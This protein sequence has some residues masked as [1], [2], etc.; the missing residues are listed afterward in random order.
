MS[1]FDKLKNLGRGGKPLKSPKPGGI[2]GLAKRD[3]APANAPKPAAPAPDAA[4][5][6]KM[7]LNSAPAKKS[8]GLSLSLNKGPKA[9]SQATP[10][11]A[12]PKS[13][14]A[15]PPALTQTAPATPPKSTGGMSIASFLGKEERPP[16]D[17]G[18]TELT[19]M[20]AE[21]VAEGT[22]FDIRMLMDDWPNPDDDDEYDPG[23]REEL[24]CDYIARAV[25]RLNQLFAEQMDLLKVADAGHPV[26]AEI[27]RIV[28][29]TYFRVKDAPGAYNILSTSDRS[30]Y[31]RALIGLGDKRKAAASKAGKT[32]K[33]KAEAS[34]AIDAASNPS[35]ILAADVA[36][37]VAIMGDI[38]GDDLADS[39]MFGSM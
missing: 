37:Q 1:A 21:M 10:Q 6:N 33:A 16:V 39:D 29:L 31:V 24:R 19:Q 13:G 12:A 15:D 28:K 20:A 4:A 2:A 34:A 14:V 3:A 11:T 23:T 26:M 25:A 5:P 7:G 27:A 36:E 18:S 17:P 32:K 38:M 9:N 22:F 35:D 8:G 30:T